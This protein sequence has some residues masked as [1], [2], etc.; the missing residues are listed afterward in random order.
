VPLPWGVPPLPLLEVCFL[1]LCFETLSATLRYAS[2]LPQCAACRLEVCFL[3]LSVPSLKILSAALRFP[4]TPCLP[5]VSSVPV[6]SSCALAFSK[7]ASCLQVCLCLDMIF[8]A[9]R[10]SPTTS[11]LPFTPRCAPYHLGRP[12]VSRCA[13]ASRFVCCLEVTHASHPPQACLSA[14][15]V[16]LSARAVSFLLELCPPACSTMPSAPVS[17]S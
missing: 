5:P 17:A 4:P 14:R 16:P 2:C 3:F 12:L 8:A 9:S 7:R 10:L 6:G 13:S 15:V 11:S 1:C